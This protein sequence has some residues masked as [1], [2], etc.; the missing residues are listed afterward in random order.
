MVYILSVI[1]R[2]QEYNQWCDLCGFFG[3][4]WYEQSIHCKWKLSILIVRGNQGTNNGNGV[5]KIL[6]N[7]ESKSLTRDMLCWRRRHTRQTVLE[8][9]YT[10]QQGAHGCSCMTVISFKGL[11]YQVGMNRPG[12][13]PLSSK[14]LHHSLK[15]LK[16]CRGRFWP[17]PAIRGWCLLCLK[18][19]FSMIG[20]CFPRTS[21]SSRSDWSSTYGSIKTRTWSQNLHPYRYHTRWKNL[22][23]LHTHKLLP[24]VGAKSAEEARKWYQVRENTRYE[25]ICCRKGR[26]K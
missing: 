13:V 24:K 4:T 7:A 15:H 2:M 17:L 10:P 22:Q 20:W 6:S 5:V 9:G 21:L 18:V 3:Q 25:V 26:R 19:R 12:T 16:I 23:R 1:Y 8:C 11:W 14:T